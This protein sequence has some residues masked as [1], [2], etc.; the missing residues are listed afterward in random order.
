LRH[1]ASDHIIGTSGSRVEAIN[2]T[3]GLAR[4][5]CCRLRAT[6]CSSSLHARTKLGP[7]ETFQALAHDAVE[8]LFGA[9]AGPDRYREP[10]P[11]RFEW[12]GLK[13][14]TALAQ[15]ADNDVELTLWNRERRALYRCD[16][17]ARRAKLKFGLVAMT[18]LE[19]QLICSAVRHPPYAAVFCGEE[20]ARPPAAS[21]IS[22]Q[23]QPI[24]AAA[25][26]TASSSPISPASSSVTQTWPRPSVS[27]SRTSS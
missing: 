11:T 27:N 12:P 1:G 20:V 2:A 26:H 24:S 19:V 21:R 25:W 3:V 15:D 6:A 7:A 8:Q 4:S 9:I 16:A 13:N 18:T 10:Q 22:R 5:R 17:L 23:P 14:G